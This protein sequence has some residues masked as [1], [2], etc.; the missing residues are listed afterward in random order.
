MVVCGH[1]M[2]SEGLMDEFKVLV[3]ACMR[4]CWTGMLGFELRICETLTA[5]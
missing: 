5:V 1:L 4:A 2:D 3:D